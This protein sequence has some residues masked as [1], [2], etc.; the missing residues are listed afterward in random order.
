MTVSLV[1]RQEGVLESLLFSWQRLDRKGKLVAASAGEAVFPGLGGCR[2]DADRTAVHHL[3]DHFE[4][5]LLHL[6]CKSGTRPRLIF[7]K[8]RRVCGMAGMSEV[9]G[10]FW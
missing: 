8:T 6:F 2:M 4:K 9:V 10:P 1:A 7:G 5:G 3:G